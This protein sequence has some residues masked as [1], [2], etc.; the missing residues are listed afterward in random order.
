MGSSQSTARSAALLC[1]QGT[2][3]CDVVPCQKSHVRRQM[4]LTQEPNYQLT[5]YVW[6][7]GQVHLT[8]DMGRSTFDNFR[9]R[10]LELGQ[11]LREAVL[12]IAEKHHAFGV[13]VELVVHAGKTGTHAALQNDDGAR[14]IHFED[15]HPV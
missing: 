5:R 10:L 15:R 13:V 12:C 4:N 9:S 6:S 14:A 8:F 11:Q 7:L 3:C 2:F 1:N